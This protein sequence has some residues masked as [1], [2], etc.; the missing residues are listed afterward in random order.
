[1]IVEERIIME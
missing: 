1:M